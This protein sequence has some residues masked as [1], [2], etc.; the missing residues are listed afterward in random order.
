MA[1][2]VEVSN[3]AL[4]KLGASDTIVSPD[5]DSH[6]ARTVSAVWDVVR[7]A[8]LRGIGEQIPRWNFAERYAETPARAPTASNPIPYGWA[9]AYPM[10]DGALRLAEI[11]QPAHLGAGG[12]KLVGNESAR[13]VLLKQPGP[14][15]AWWLF[16]VPEPGLWDDS[17]VQAMAA[18]LGFEIADRITGDMGRKQACWDEFRANLAAAAKVDAM[19][20]API[21]PEEDDWIACR[22]GAGLPYR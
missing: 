16:D 14:L 15:K 3:L 11:V 18:R 8:T 13:E 5:D 19:E 9:G 17:F 10:P 22:Y 12:W 4:F 21:E 6:A 7:K 20:G 2:R 1:S